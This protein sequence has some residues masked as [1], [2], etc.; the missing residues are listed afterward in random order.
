M[1]CCARLLTKLVMITMQPSTLSHARSQAFDTFSCHYHSLSVRLCIFAHTSATTGLHYPYCFLSDTDSVSIPTWT[2]H[3]WPFP[4][5]YTK[6][7][8]CNSRL[9]QTLTQCCNLVCC[10]CF[11]CSFHVIVASL[12]NNIYVILAAALLATLC[13]TADTLGTWHLTLVISATFRS[14]L[15]ALWRL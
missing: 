11:A 10:S 4:H 15:A 14:T 13:L 2:L 3:G 12:N 8:C 6:F 1:T 5:T 9:S 7:P